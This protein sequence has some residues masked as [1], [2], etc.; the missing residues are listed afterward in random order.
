MTCLTDRNLLLFV[1]SGLSHF[2][3]TLRPSSALTV[4][5]LF[6]IG[7][8]Q[9]NTNAF[10]S[11]NGDSSQRKLKMLE[12]LALMSFSFFRSTCVSDFAGWPR[13]MNISPQLKQICI[14]A[15]SSSRTSPPLIFC[16]LH[17]K[18][19]S[20]CLRRDKMTGHSHDLCRVPSGGKAR[21]RSAA[22]FSM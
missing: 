5:T 4:V 16:P 19:L 3:A 1:F 12:R 9:P 18:M 14:F 10:L 21:G 7:N 8:L 6:P 13:S 15:H 17:L 2:P 20:L 22:I 11:Q